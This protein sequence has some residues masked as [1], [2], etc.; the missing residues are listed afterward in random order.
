MKIPYE[1]DPELGD[2]D[3]PEYQE[4]MFKTFQSMCWTPDK[5]R[6]PEWRDLYAEWLKK[7]Q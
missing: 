5:I 6:D 7:Q 1:E 2:E 3:D 4:E